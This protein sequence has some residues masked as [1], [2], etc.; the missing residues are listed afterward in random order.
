MEAFLQNG[1][2]VPFEDDDIRIA[3]DTP[4]REMRLQADLGESVAQEFQRHKE[5]GNIFMANRLG[6][7]LARP[8][9]EEPAE[10]FGDTAGVERRQVQ[11]LYGFVVR[12]AIYEGI[13][14]SILADT[15]LHSFLETVEHFS[16]LIYAALTDS[17]SLTVYRLCLSDEQSVGGVFAK[18]TESPPSFGETLYARY[19]DF[20]RKLVGKFTFQP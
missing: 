12:L 10:L 20:A 14:V 6:E 9:R 15:A 4:S 16:G 3:S 7:E 1:A 8:L 5:N 13:D 17:V 18:L 2:G 11:F 19:F